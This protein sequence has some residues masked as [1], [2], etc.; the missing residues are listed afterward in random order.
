MEGGQEDVSYGHRR[1]RK[2]SLSCFSS[3]TFHISPDT[4]NQ[5]RVDVIKAERYCWHLPL[6]LPFELRDAKIT[7]LQQAKSVCKWRGRKS[8][9]ELEQTSQLGDE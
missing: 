4:F 8:P 3:V 9:L 2:T 7:S 6:F 1:E 5:H